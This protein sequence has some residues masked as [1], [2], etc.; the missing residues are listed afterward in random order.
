MRTLDRRS[1]DLRCERKAGTG[2]PD[3]AD[4]R[5]W[6]LA[7]LT[8][9]GR[10]LDTV[11][12]AMSQDFG[13]SDEVRTLPV[14]TRIVAAE[15]DMAPPSHYVEVFKLLDGGLRG[16]GWT[17]EGRP[18]GGH[19]LAIPPV[20]ACLVDPLALGTTDQASRAWQWRRLDRAAACRT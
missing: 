3:A 6:S 2:R 17:G 10:L 5:R 18:R 13:F 19:A 20:T 15:A 7:R 11:G 14:P 9:L 4:R 8:D 12:E 16:G 1:F